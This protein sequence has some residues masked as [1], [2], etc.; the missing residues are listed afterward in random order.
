MV[1]KNISHQFKF[2]AAG[3]CLARNIREIT[4]DPTE[5][6]ILRGIDEFY[7]FCEKYQPLL[8]EDLIVL[9]PQGEQNAN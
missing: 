8:Q 4:K 3:L 1:L 6:R 5:E 9:F 7:A 2:M